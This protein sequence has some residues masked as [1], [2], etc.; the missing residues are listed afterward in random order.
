[1]LSKKFCP[2]CGSEDVHLVAGG[3]TGTWVCK[4]C[5]YTGTL[6]PER[7]IIGREVKTGGEKNEQRK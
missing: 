6:F 1:M 3:M 4:K 2:K 7:E 5:K